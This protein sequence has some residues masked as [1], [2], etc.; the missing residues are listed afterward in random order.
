MAQ[1]TDEF[2][3]RFPNLSQMLNPSPEAVSSAF[4]HF[5][6]TN[7]ITKTIEGFLANSGVISPTQVGPEKFSPLDSDI[8]RRMRIVEHAGGQDDVISSIHPTLRDG[9]IVVFHSSK[10]SVGPHELVH[11][12]VTETIFHSERRSALNVPRLVFDAMEKG[13]SS[14]ELMSILEQL[15]ENKRKIMP[16]I[17][18]G[19]EFV[20]NSIWE[21]RKPEFPER[22]KLLGELAG[23]LEKTDPDFHTKLDEVMSQNNLKRLG[24]DLTGVRGHNAPG[25]FHT[26]T[27]KSAV[28]RG[29]LPHFMR[30]GS[31]EDMFLHAYEIDAKSVLPSIMRDEAALGGLSFDEDVLK[32]SEKR[33]QIRQMLSGV[34]R[35]RTGY[36]SCSQSN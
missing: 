19:K 10:N 25:V 1:F 32:M 5:R 24:S 16:G 27:I 20:W 28:E 6:Q 21:D 30:S 2:F 17:S 34:M 4:D 11:R 33:F 36:W 31:G 8:G 23:I 3:E 35:R 9:K 15:D 26:G 22:R 12:N 13:D 18:E 29:N 14:P 7:E